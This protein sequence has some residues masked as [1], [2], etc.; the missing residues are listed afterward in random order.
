MQKLFFLVFI[1]LFLFTPLPVLAET[2]WKIT[3]FH[4][5]IT[6]QPDG[7]VSIKEKISVDFNS[8]EKHGIYRDIPYA[9][10]SSTGEKTYT[11][12]DLGEVIQDNERA[13]IETSNNG[14]NFRIRIGDPDT[15]ITGKHTYQISYIATGVLLS[16]PDYDELYWNVTGQDWEADIEKVSASVTLPKEKIE[17]MN[18]F[19]GYSGSTLM[20]SISQNSPTT[21]SFASTNSLYPQQGI[22]IGVGFTKGIV[23]I[24]TVS[25]PRT[26]F[27]EVQTLPS[28][29]TLVVTIL[30]GSGVI[31]FVWMS[32]GR[33]L[34]FRTRR[35]LSSDA[36]EEYRPFWAFEP[37]VVEFESPEKLPPAILGVVMDEKADTL[38]VTATLVDLATRGFMT[39]TEI[40]KKWL[41]GTVDY[42]LSSTGKAQEKLYGYEKTLLNR[43]FSGDKE[44]VLVSSLKKTFYDDLAV[45]KTQLYEE[46]V[47][48]KLFSTHPETT[49]H[50]YIGISIL[51]VI[52][53]GG[54]IKFSFDYLFGLGVMFGIGVILSGII[55]LF[56]SGSMPRRSA[57]GREVYQRAKGYRMF[58]SGAE[59]YR[60]QFFEKK[61]MFNDVLP[62]AIIFGLTEKFAQ[63]MKEMGLKP[64][65]PSWYS[66]SRVFTPSYFVSD[67]NSF[68]KSLSSAIASTP[69]SSGSSGGSSGGG[70]GG[71]GGGS[72]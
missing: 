10:E 1:C 38:D 61:N 64:S 42:E 51:I 66:G 65:S 48:K 21:V 63:S 6:I 53:G 15:T 55:L 25:P 19:E 62:Y 11:T 69:S 68:S 37:L 44:K 57:Y 50:K 36:K 28:L 60:Q 43:L 59:K 40:P 7:K 2:D 13:V 8:L 52:V 56:S 20:C 45:V 34:W 54:I 31:F 67:V 9:Y 4:S 71:G 17:V 12:L 49:R 72:W 3:D 70:F 26:I 16:H 5:D 46:V 39:I 27:D 47:K 33:D 29:I 22:T 14:A 23:P 41:F 30:G 58:I 32:N 24:I 35:I 18:C